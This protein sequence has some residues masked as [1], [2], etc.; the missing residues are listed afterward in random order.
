M[1]L[2]EK[3]VEKLEHSA[4]DLLPN[5]LM[6]IV[7]F[8]ISYF[9]AKALKK[10]SLTFYSKLFKEKKKSAEW[11]SKIIYI[12]V[13]ILGVLTA[14]DIIGLDSLVTKLM[15]GAGILGVVAGFAF[16]EIGSNIFAGLLINAQKPFKVDDWVEIDGQF[17][18]VVSVTG[19]TTSIKTVSGQEVFVPNQII[20]R[21][22]FTNFSTFGKRR[23]ILKS[24]V[25]YG[26]D[27]ER[28]KQVALDE[29]RKIENINKNEG[30][31][32]YFTGIGSSTYDFELRYWIDYKEQV[33]YMKAMNETII[34]LKKRFEQE[35]ISIAYSVTTLDFG[36]K[37]GVNLFDKPLQIDH[38]KD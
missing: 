4:Y 23:V 31:E 19:I 8:L 32:F 21:S 24:G 7:V 33:D 38:K 37:G 20:Y 29:V 36:V 18:K 25:S 2:V 22:S 14:I 13:L 17:G 16:K 27:L 12:V 30:I 1:N 28:V 11:I 9:L 6:A 10:I 26:D 34:R 15:A 35:D 5:I 3:G